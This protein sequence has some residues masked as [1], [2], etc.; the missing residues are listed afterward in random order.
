M[1]PNAM[2]QLQGE[3]LRPQTQETALN[4]NTKPSGT[5]T[6]QKSLSFQRGA[7]TSSG[8]GWRPSAPPALL[9]V[10]PHIIIQPQLTTTTPNNGLLKRQILG[11]G[12][13][14]QEKKKKKRWACEEHSHLQR[15]KQP[16]GRRGGSPLCIQLPAGQLCP[17]VSIARGVLSTCRK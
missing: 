10:E 8:W 13:L 11:V 16:S 14:K 6:E 4:P 3:V 9:G 12:K 2:G 15:E 5:R 17:S 1:P 7:Q